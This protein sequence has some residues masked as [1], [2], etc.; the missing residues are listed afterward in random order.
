MMTTSVNEKRETRRQKV[1]K[2]AKIAF[3]SGGGIDCVVRNISDGGARLDVES[4]IGL[5]ASFTLLIEADQVTRRCR[6]VTSS[7]K[8]VR[9]A[10][11]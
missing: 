7:A 11:D 6:L 4:P 9:I 5:P 10:F 2:S 1:L 8:Q 3:D